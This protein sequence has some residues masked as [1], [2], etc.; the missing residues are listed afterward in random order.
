MLNFETSY[1]CIVAMSLLHIMGM[2]STTYSH[3]VQK[4]NNALNIQRRMKKQEAEGKMGGSR[5]IRNIWKLNGRMQ[6][7]EKEGME[8]ERQQ[9]RG[10]GSRGEDKEEKGERR[11]EMADVAEN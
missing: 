2:M 6:D 3:M 9:E 4:K 11:P 5:E 1:H 7:R 8:R 10:R